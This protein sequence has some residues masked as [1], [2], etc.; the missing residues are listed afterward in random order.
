LKRISLFA[1][2]GMLALAIIAPGVASAAPQRNQLLTNVP[3][4]GALSDGG[5]FAGNLSLT[6]IT[7]TATGALQFAGNLTG[8]ATDA[9][10]AT[11]AINQTFTAVAGSLTGPATGKC[12]IL[13]LDLGPLFL[14]LLGLQVDLNEVIL[15]VDA[16]PG[17]GNLLGNLLCGV[18]GL[19]DGGPTGAL[20]NLLG[21]INRLLG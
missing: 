3:V 18:V 1:V 21:I 15:N 13:H 2:V 8:T 9:L 11:T 20:N 7:R 5:S 19:L 10:G 4:A 17:P 16:Q 14:D 6:S 12:A